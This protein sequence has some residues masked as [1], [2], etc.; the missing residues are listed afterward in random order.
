MTEIV[1]LATPYSDPD[2][3]VMDARFKVVNHVAAILMAQGVFVFS[4]ISHTH[5]IALAGDLPRGWEFWEG[6]DRAMIGACQRLVVL[7][8]DGWTQSTGVRSEIK[9]ATE[10]RLPVEYIEVPE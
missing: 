8:Q 3:V 5:P 7:K 6:Y 9:I 2:P 10:L 1:Y 4:P